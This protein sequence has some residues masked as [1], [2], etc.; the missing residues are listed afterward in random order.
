MSNA[1]CVIMAYNR[2]GFI[3]F[4]D[5]LPPSEV[6][7]S[8]EDREDPSSSSPPPPPQSFL[9][10]NSTAVDN[11]EYFDSPMAVPK[12]AVHNLPQ[13][14]V[15][16]LKSEKTPL[17]LRSMSSE[18]EGASS[19]HD[20]YNET[21]QLNRQKRKKVPVMIIPPRTESTV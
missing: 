21:D 14:N 20:Y 5:Y 10:M 8:I 7:D 11:P 12:Q 19:E 18:S 2:I 1:V 15:D 6:G 17:R 9:D 4:A 16:G 3:L 13:V